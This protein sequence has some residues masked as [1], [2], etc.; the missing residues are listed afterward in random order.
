MGSDLFKRPL[1]GGSPLRI[2]EDAPTTAGIVGLSWF[3][4]GT[5]LYEQFGAADGL[6][7]R[8]V[9]RISEEGGEP[10]EV[11][12]GVGE[13]VAIIWVHGLPGARGALV[14]A[15]PGVLCP[16]GATQLHIVDLEDLS[17]EV[18]RSSRV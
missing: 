2:A 14:I 16:S 1:V 18:S 12:F 11:V 8:R 17:S 4:D 9:A 3:D 13:E 15:C 5:I 6:S 7:T 10:L